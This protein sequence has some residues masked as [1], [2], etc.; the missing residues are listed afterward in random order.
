MLILGGTTLG[1]ELAA[2]VHSLPVDCI[3]SLA[4]RTTPKSLPEVQVRIG[5][6]GGA[7]ALADYL[8]DENISMV[9][10]ATHAYAAQISANAE[11]AC[12]AANVPLFRLQEPPWQQ[13][14]GDHW[15]PVADVAAARD[16]AANIAQ[17][18]FVTTGRQSAAEFAND[19]SCW[20]LLRMVPTTDTLPQ[21]ANG[22]YVFER[23]PFDLDNERQLLRG[24]DVEAIISK[25]AGS[26]ATYAKIIA[27]RELS[28]PVIM[29]ER[30]EAADVTQVATV[31]DAIEWLKQQ[32]LLHQSS[33]AKG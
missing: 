1:R 20:W 7:E 12:E 29:I 5:G 32:V 24:H 9:I 11:A 13:Q 23:G 27:A 30:P 3:Y 19:S 8:R 28:L 33:S 15:I 6:F 21:L 22:D 16:A 26:E 18:V 25:N 14:D 2:A 4:G 17:R 31:I 10:D